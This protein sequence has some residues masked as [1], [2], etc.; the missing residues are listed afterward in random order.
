MCEWKIN[1]KKI[2]A[3]VEPTILCLLLH[4]YNVINMIILLRGMIILLR[5]MIIMWS[6]MIIPLNHII[7][8]LCGMTLL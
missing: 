1:L 8:I 5:G 6:G 4:E 2:V 7:K 3:G